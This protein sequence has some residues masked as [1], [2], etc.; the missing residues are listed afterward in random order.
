MFCCVDGDASMGA[1]EMGFGS[2]RAS[3]NTGNTAQ[4]AAAAAAAGNSTA[5][6]GIKRFGFKSKALRVTKPTASPPPVMDKAKPS[7]EEAAASEL[8]REGSYGDLDDDVGGN[9]KRPADGAVL[10]SSYNPAAV[11]PDG[12]KRRTS[13]D[14]A[15]L[16]PAVA[17]SVSTDTASAGAKAALSVPTVSASTPAPLAAA[18]AA[19]A[20]TLIP[21]L[22]DENMAPSGM[23][24][25]F[26]KP[27]SAVKLAPAAGMHQRP[28][29][30]P[31]LFDGTPSNR[32][33]IPDAQELMAAGSRQQGLQARPTASQHAAQVA[34]AAGPNTGPMQGGGAG[35]EQTTSSGAPAP[36]P[37]INLA[38]APPERLNEPQKR[39]M[40]DANWVYV[41]GLRY[42]KL[43][44]VGRGGSSKVF[45]V[46]NISMAVHYESRSSQDH[47]RHQGQPPHHSTPHACQKVYALR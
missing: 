14:N 33:N 45:K 8:P 27:L 10:H 21:P 20:R 35:G 37:S 18:A 13:P 32:A 17:S 46:C 30:P 40:E 41:S 5:Q 15:S 9:R 12:I 24:H 7:A 19:P 43:D 22:S 34:G 3:S 44:C 38:V 28:A 1:D 31:P 39:A 25:P 42:Q 2:M 11:M 16:R 36:N 4:Q 6:I 23:P 26:G 29:P 47:C